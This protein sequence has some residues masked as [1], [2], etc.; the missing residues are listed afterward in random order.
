MELTFS[1][2]CS[3]D[4][5]LAST[6]AIAAVLPLLAS[7]VELYGEVGDGVAYLPGSCLNSNNAHDYCVC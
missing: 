1:V 2:S 4:P 6:A 3:L 7:K 5:A